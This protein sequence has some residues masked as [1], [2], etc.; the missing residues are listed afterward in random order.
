MSS[1][2]Y[3]PYKSSSN[4]IKVDLDLINYATKKDINDITHVDLSGFATETNLAALK[5][6]VDKTDVDKLKT[7][8]VDLPKLSNVVNNDV[9]KKIDYNTK[10]TS[11]ENQIAGVTKNTLD[12]L[13]DI[14]K[15]KA[16][17]TS[18]FVSKTKFTADTNTL[19]NEIDDADKKIPDVSGLATKS[20]LTAY[21]QTVTFNSKVTE[22]ENKI[23]ANDTLAKSVG[24]RITSIETNLNGFKKSDLTGYAKKA[25]FAT[26]ITTK[27]KNYV[28]NASLTNQLNDLTSQHIT[29]EVKKVEDKVNE[30]KKEI[31]FVRGFFSYEYHSDL[32]YDCKLNLI[33]THSHGILEWKP[34]NIYDPSS[35]NVLNSVQN[36]KLISSNIKN[37]GKGLH[38][39][40][41]GNY[42]QQ[43]IIAIPNNAIN[44]YCVYEL[45]PIDFS[46]NNEYTIQNALFGA[47][48]ITK[49]ANTSK[50]KYKGYGICFD[51]SESFSHVR[52]EGNCNH[53]T[54][55]RNVIIF[56]ADMSFSKHANN[57]ANNIYVMG[58]DYIQKINDTTIYAEKMFY[59]NF[60]DP[61][62]Q[63]ILSLHYN[64]DHSYLFVNGREEL[65]FKTKTDQI[66]NKNL[67]LGN[68]SH[69]WT[70]YQSTKTSLYGNIYDFVVDYK[71]IVR[72]TTIYDMHRYLMTE[73][74]IKPY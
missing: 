23:K 71:A 20:S 5:T 52:K 55:A 40:F 44:I 43:D 35:K 26:D 36:I 51:E 62:K 45:D 57:K 24:T 64:G 60:T 41:S 17:D 6:E 3:P 4:N 53:T 14:T 32:V 54:L 9:V 11:I 1:Q 16:V 74:N 38:V 15:L 68:L 47:I 46:R 56:G 22:V 65:K 29:D 70:R 18:N 50:Y 63:F 12:N 66:I 67:W 13:G 31:I 42:F 10:V 2:Y 72:T 30:N 59:R 61:G 28:T 37:D 33:K 27:K 8:P 39:F 69:D 21:L 73:H 19:E 25:D 34:K 58:R 7:V 49:N 48:E